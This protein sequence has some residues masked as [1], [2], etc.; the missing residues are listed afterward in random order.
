MPGRSSRDLDVW[1]PVQHDVPHSLAMTDPA[2]YRSL[3]E[4]VTQSHLRGGS[5]LVLAKI[6]ALAAAS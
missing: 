1:Q 2:L 3:R 6:E 5:A 4:G